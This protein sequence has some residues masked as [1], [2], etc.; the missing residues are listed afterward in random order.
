MGFDF[1][2]T[3]SRTVIERKYVLKIS[4]IKFKICE[5][6]TG[7][8]HQE[9]WLVLPENWSH[10]EYSVDDG[11]MYFSDKNLAAI[12]IETHGWYSQLLI[13]NLVTR[14]RYWIASDSLEDKIY[15]SPY[16][17]DVDLEDLFGPG[18]LEIRQLRLKPN[19]IEI[20][21]QTKFMEYTH[22]CNIDD[23]SQESLGQS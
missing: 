6:S 7:N 19:Q 13:L 18:E 9:E 16:L 14:K 20:Q 23:M 5:L 11:W 21:L 2:S 4:R 3:I 15:T 10:E 1:Y 8:Q 22:F 12:E 17:P